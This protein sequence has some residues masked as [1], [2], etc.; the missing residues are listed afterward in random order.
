MGYYFTKI[1]TCSYQEAILRVKDALKTEGF[2]V[3][4]EIDVKGTLKK[5]LDVNFRDYCILGACNPSFAHRALDTERHVGLL[6]PCNVVVQTTDEGTAEVSIIDPVAA[7]E[8]VDNPEL[9]TVASEVRAKLEKVIT[10]L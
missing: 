8:A 4:T 5:K 7:M 1:L 9:A 10:I 3:L 6:L 2:G